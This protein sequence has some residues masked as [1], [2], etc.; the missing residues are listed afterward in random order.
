[1]LLS[2][3]RDTSPDAWNAVLESQRVKPG[4]QRVAGALELVGALASFSGVQQRNRTE[5]NL[6]S[7]EE[8]FRYV[9]SGLDSARIPYMIVG[10]FASTFHGIARATQDLD[11]V[12]ELDSEKM[13]RLHDLFQQPDFYF[14]SVAA[15]QALQNLGMFNLVHIPTGWKIDFIL[16]KERPFSKR[17]F[18][19]R[20]QGEILGKKVY[21]AT[22]EDTVLAK[23]EWA[24][25]SQSERQ[26]RDVAEIFDIQGSHLDSDY[27]ER[28]IRELQLQSIRE[29]VR[30]PW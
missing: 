21:L 13:E 1:M 8:L 11:I 23:L 12:C 18:A 17:E 14:N 16:R 20:M 25:D 4:H 26:L 7:L 27:I 24:K 9:V 15:E 2:L 30:G 29:K 28:G 22:P 10:S 3:P 19:R 5:F 6:R